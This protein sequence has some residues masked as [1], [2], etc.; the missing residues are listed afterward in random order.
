M[1]NKVNLDQMSEEDLLKVRICDL[2]VRIAETWLAECIQ[3]LYE[4]LEAKGIV[5]RP[6]CYLT[7]EW[8]TPENQPIIG[9]P[10]F[11]AHPAL[12]RLEKKMMLEAEGETVTACMQLLRHE[13]GH[14]ICYAYQLNRRSKFRQLFGSSKKAYSET[15][16]Y[17]PY[18]K[19]FVRHLEGFYAQY[20]PDEDFVETFAV[21]LTPG[22]DWAKQYQGWPA[23]RKL[24]Y[25]DE[26]MRHIKAREP[27]I[28]KGKKFWQA[29]TIKA[30]LATFY[31]RRRKLR[32]EDFPDFHDNNLKR[33][34]SPAGQDAPSV[35]AADFLR[36]HRPKI[37][38][39]ISL[40]T[41]EKKY[42][43]NDLLRHIIQRCGALRLAVG[44][45]EHIVM[46]RFISY[47][48]TLVMNYVYT[49]WYRGDHRV[50][51]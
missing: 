30:S 3:R 22:L 32:A 50:R 19:S 4:E 34:F 16:R 42:V 10:F 29:K 17:R 13:T 25:I 36:R 23:L 26:L 9:I 51:K 33:I 6:E 12:I 28:K 24:Q 37:V 38:Q 39:E 31:R 40:W 18:S 27:R 45:P 11:L 20:H 47:I 41:G 21:W 8:L 44:E 5:F 15:Y 2:P 14:A 46:V 35:L 43:I 48:T 1:P 7:D 49:G